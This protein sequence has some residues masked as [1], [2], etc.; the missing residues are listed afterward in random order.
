MTATQFQSPIFP[1]IRLPHLAGIKLPQLHRVEIKQPVA[2]ALENLEEEVANALAGCQQLMQIPEGCE[3]AIAV[4]SRGIAQI[5]VIT[6][7]VVKR[8]Q[9][10]NFRPFIVPAMGS[11]GGGTAEGQQKVLKKL[12]IDEASLG[13]EVR[14]SMKTVDYG[15]IAEGIHCHFD[16]NAAAAGGV[17]LIN[18][19]KA[20][21]SFPREIESGLIKLVAVGLGKAE[22]AR[23]VHRI[24]PRGL[25][26]VLPK[27]A[28]KA[29]QSA[30]IKAGL[31]LIENANREICHLEAIEPE[32]L[33]ETE[34]KLLRKAK[35][36]MP[37]LP[38][39]Q[40]DA[41]VVE[42][43]GKE[44]SG[45]GLDPHI[46]GRTDIRGVENP[47]SPFIHKIAGLRMTET[48]NLNGMG[49]GM[50]DF[51]PQPTANQLNLVSMYMN[52]VSSTLLEKAFLPIVL[53]NDQEVIRALVATCWQPDLESI[54]LAQ[55]RSTLH[56][57]EMLLT[58]PLFQ[59][60]QAKSTIA[61][62]YDQTESFEFDSLG[63]LL[64]RVQC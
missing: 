14:S 32:A 40:L 7:T 19:V 20:H 33:F 42:E 62:Y 8:L 5:D 57:N 59:E 10:M 6:Q 47:A 48:T 23:A 3:I 44:I 43:F 61:S 30:P 29:I 35:D 17:L 39:D 36:L 22:G 55:I 27:L 2:P 21:T 49:T 60:A 4:G 41:L 53:A 63:Q 58:T 11:H 18:R 52:A 12:G 31:A 28:E 37:S 13:C 1:E 51:L 56:L 9:Q 16:A 26:E 15:S 46:S 64:T 25:Q 54:R 24:G 38:F 34:K 45:A 50:L